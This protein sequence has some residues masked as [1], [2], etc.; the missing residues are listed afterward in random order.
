MGKPGRFNYV[1]CVLWT[2]LGGLIGAAAGL[3]MAD[4]S[5]PSGA[6]RVMA[7]QF[8]LITSTPKTIGGQTI[9]SINVYPLR[10]QTRLITFTLHAEDGS[11]KTA[12]A[13][14]N[15]PFITAAAL[16][17]I[18]GAA[19]RQVLT[20]PD[21]LATV[22]AARVAATDADAQP[23]H[24]W[25]SA[26]AFLDHAKA[27]HPELAYTVVPWLTSAE[28][29]RNGAILGA[30]GLGVIGSL[31]FARRSDSDLLA[32]Q[33]L[34]EASPP[35]PPPAPT[36][37]TAEDLA[38]LAELD[39]MLSKNLQPSGEASTQP[40]TVIIEPE[41]AIATLR[42]ETV[43]A[44]PEKPE[45]EKDYKGEFYPAARGPKRSGFSLIE[46]LVVI[47]VIGIL[48][49]LLLPTLMRARRSADT[50]ACAANLRGP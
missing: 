16:K 39:A 40:A 22:G 6:P 11:S 46:L 12:Y 9:D 28:R 21:A 36:G 48:I 19:A 10:L 3:L 14:A 30:I 13:F 24:R 18:Q 34:A 37:P 43:E 44:A 5:A 23:D 2:A 17:A 35:T 27:N 45:E 32:A 41:P 15:E 8:V 47:G 33:L 29:A 31:L 38:R 26:M 20:K 42:T 1:K 4:P 49:A 50:I 25:A 7:P